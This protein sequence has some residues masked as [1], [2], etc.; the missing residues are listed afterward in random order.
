MAARS[1]KVRMDAV[2]GRHGLEPARSRNGIVVRL[3]GS[4]SS[5]RTPFRH[6]IDSVGDAARADDGVVNVTLARRTSVSR[7]RAN[8]KLERNEIEALVRRYR[9][10]ATVYE[11][12]EEFGMHRQ[13][14]SAHLHREGIALRSRVRMTPQLLARATELYEAGWSTVRIGKEL[15]LGT[16]TV[17]KALKRAGVPMRQ[18]VADRWKSDG[19]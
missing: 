8:R 10:G 13:T 11:L 14:V 7:P 5:Q 19:R 1:W 18:P 2:S 9:E 3:R 16:S 6:L 12:A 17:G 4:L 15:G